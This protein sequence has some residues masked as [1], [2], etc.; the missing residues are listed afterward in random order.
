MLVV[1]FVLVFGAASLITPYFLV[2]D[3]LLDTTLN[4]MEKAIVALPMTLSIILGDIDISVAG[5]MALSSLTMG[6]ASTAGAG[7]LAL[8]ALGLVTGLAAGLLNGLVATRFGIPTIAVTIGSVSL[9]RGI[10]YAVLG[11]KAYTRYPEPFAVLGQGYIPGTKIPLQL[12]LYLVLA[13]GFWLLLH[14]SAFGRRVYAIGSNRVA[15][16][17]SGVPVDRIRITVSGL[18]GLMSG[19]ASVLLTARIGSTRPNI[20]TGYE[21]EIIT[22][23]VLGG[24]AI[25][26]GRGTMAGVVI[27]TFL[28]GYLKFALGLVNV[29]G[30]V[31]NIVTGVLL[32][33]AILLPGRVAALQARVGLQREQRSNP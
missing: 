31:I 9:Y 13:V 33:L 14:Y 2:L 27:G 23:V 7:T 8:V 21:M 4:F 5:T 22:I 17:F 6:A 18:T 1:L 29:P 10:A 26:G 11:D 19:L 15:A 32:V 30:K 12:V 24:V 28:I 20:A 16:R 25:T 3:N